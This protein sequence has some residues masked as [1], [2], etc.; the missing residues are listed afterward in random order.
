ML[1]EFKAFV[2]RGNVLDLAIATIIGVT[3]NSIVSSIID[4]IFMPIIGILMGGKNFEKMVITIGEAEIK[5]GLTLAAI[6]KFLVVALFL[7][8][9]IKA[10]NKFRTKEE[11]A[12]APPA[13]DS[14]TEKL[15]AEILEQMKKN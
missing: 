11:E 5:Y 3:F 7:F 1:K 15:L 8:I 14:K 6:T 2:F 10:V 13:E 9:I 4:N 12:P